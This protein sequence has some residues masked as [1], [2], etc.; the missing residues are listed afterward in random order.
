MKMFL[1][2]LPMVYT[3]R[4]LFK[5]FERICSHVD[6]FNNRN[7]LLTSK[8]LKQS[9]CYHK[10]RKVFTKFYYRHWELIV[11]YNICLK[12]LLQQGISKPAFNGDLV[13]KFKR[14]VGKPIILVINLKILLNILKVW[15]TTWISCDSLHAWL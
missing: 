2:L 5:C 9:Y 15:D 8:L 14:V 13:Y 6:D 10:L 12:I 1:A 11:K 4:N 7:K 3:F